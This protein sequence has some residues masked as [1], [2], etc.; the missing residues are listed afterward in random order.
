VMAVGPGAQL[1]LELKYDR[2]RVE[3][4]GAQRIAAALTGAL[5]VL[6]RGAADRVSDLVAAMDRAEREQ[7]QQEQALAEETAAE[8]LQ[9]V[10]QS[11]ARRRRHAEVDDGSP[12]PRA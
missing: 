9:T 2:R 3:R 4:P 5:D 10:K 6:A 8:L 12:T 1:T 11:A 7:R